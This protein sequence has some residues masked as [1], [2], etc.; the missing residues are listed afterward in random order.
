M[1]LIQTD[2]S[3]SLSRQLLMCSNVSSQPLKSCSSDAGSLTVAGVPFAAAVPAATYQHTT[4]LKRMWREKKK[5]L[6]ENSEFS[7]LFYFIPHRH[8]QSNLGF[9]NRS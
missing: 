4:I 9:F 6:N 8:C 7:L 1:L 2:L 5:H 3:E